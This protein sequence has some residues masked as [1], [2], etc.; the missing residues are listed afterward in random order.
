MGDYLTETVSVSVRVN[1]KQSQKG[2]DIH[3]MQTPGA[4][5]DVL[6]W[7]EQHIKWCEPLL[8]KEGFWVKEFKIKYQRR[9][10]EF[11]FYQQQEQRAPAATH[12]PPPPPVEDV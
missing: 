8:D 3:V 2:V 5:W 1:I 6:P 7:K 11:I 10:Y 12:N 9:I 4:L